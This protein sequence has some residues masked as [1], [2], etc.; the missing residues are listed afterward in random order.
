M[1]IVTKYIPFETKGNGDVI[2]ITDAVQTSITDSG[3]GNGVV[4]IFTPSATSG[5]TTLEYESGCVEDLQRLFEEIIPSDREY[6]HNQRW[7]DGNGHSH[8][9]AALVKPSLTIPICEGMMTLGTWQSIVLIDFDNRS[10][11]RKL[12][13]QIMGE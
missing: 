3:V 8:V 7:G 1:E 11:K 4:T 9:R 12:V 2:N 6:A 10:R 5:L 13:V